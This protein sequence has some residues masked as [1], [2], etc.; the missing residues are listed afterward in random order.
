[1]RFENEILD[2]LNFQDNT[3]VNYRERRILWMCI[4]EHMWFELGKDESGNDLPE[5]SSE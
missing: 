2:T 4:I 1:M 3:V 5:F